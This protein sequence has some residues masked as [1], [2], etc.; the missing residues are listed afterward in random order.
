MRH[1]IGPI[2]LPDFF[3]DEAQ[4]T[5]AEYDR[6]LKASR[7]R[8]AHTH[9]FLEHWPNGSGVPGRDARR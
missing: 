3:I 4:V 2:T 7:Y 1:N 5:N 6:F 8:P 9:N